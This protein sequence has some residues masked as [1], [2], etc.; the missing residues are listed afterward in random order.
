MRLM[1]L[2]L[3]LSTIGLFVCITIFQHERRKTWLLVGSIVVLGILIL[4]WAIEGERVQL[5]LLYG[6]TLILVTIAGFRYFGK[7]TSFTLPRFLRRFASISII[8][9][10]VATAGM[11]YAFPVF[12]LPAPTGE[13]KVGTQTFHLVDTSRKE[14]FDPNGKRNREL[15]VQVWYPAQAN[16]EAYAPFVADADILPDIAEHYGLPGFTF[17]HLKYISSYAYADAAVASAQQTYPLII[18]N[19]GNG[20]SRFFHTSQAEELVSHGYIVV[21]IDHTYNTIATQFPDGRITTNT[22]DTLFSP[23]HD[24]QTERAQR[25]KL[26]KLLTDDVAFVLD[27]LQLIQSGHIPSSLKG[28]LDLQHIGIFGHSIGGAT[29]YDAAY[30][31]R[32]TVG[33]DLDG[34]LYRLQDRPPLRKPFLFINSASNHEAIQRVIDHDVYTDAE[35]QQMGSTRAWEDGVMKDKQLELKRMRE[36]V[37]AGGSVIYIENTEHLNFTDVQFVS[38]AFKLVGATGTILPARANEITNAY[39]LDLF[40]HYLNNRKS[41]LL[42]GP[43]RRFPEVKFIDVSSS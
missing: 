7:G 23:S 42:K 25:D 26:G 36:A 5:L 39:M 2:L 9:L 43:D 33:V 35:L 24:Y 11:L 12:H 1:E 8:L 32:I 19:P 10:F 22:S 21:M 40:D 20:S 34:G 14:S 41:D 31:P 3:F 37:V 13:W 15:M 17:Q 18:G 4:Q 27:Q 38:P 29:A 28:R 6:T 30:D 16:H